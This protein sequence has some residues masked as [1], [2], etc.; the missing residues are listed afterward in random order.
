MDASPKAHQVKPGDTLSGIAAAAHL[1]W[2][3]LARANHIDHPNLIRPGQR[4][5]LT[6]HAPVAKPET[7]TSDIHVQLADD[8]VMSLAGSSPGP[9]PGSSPPP[10]SGNSPAPDPA[11]SE[12]GGSSPAPE[13]TS[14]APETSPTP[15]ASPSPSASHTPKPKPKPKPKPTHTKKPGHPVIHSKAAAKRY[16]RSLMNAV[17]FGCFSSV[18]NHESGWRYQATN[19]SSGAY[20]LMQALPGNKMASEGADWRTNAATQIRW[21]LKYMN[22]RYGSPCGALSFWNKHRWY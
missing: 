22:S 7:G 8:M 19:P 11:A 4:I 13:T 12:T 1:G 20:G 16:A 3:C 15:S 5:M 14:P 18:V 6:C 21:G 2:R 10:D 9:D 17:Q